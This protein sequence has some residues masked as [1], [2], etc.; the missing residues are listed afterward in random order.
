MGPGVVAVNLEGVAVRLDG[1]FHI[2]VVIQ[3]VAQVEVG[4]GKLAVDLEG[5][6]QRLDGAFHVFFAKQGDATTAVGLSGVG[7]EA[8]GHREL[9]ESPV[10]IP[11]LVTQEGT[12]VDPE[13]SVVGNDF[14]SIFVGTDGSLRVAL[15]GKGDAEVK[16]SLDQGGVD[17]ER[18]LYFADGPFQVFLLTQGGAQVVV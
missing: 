4:L 18:G 9:G 12:E 16:V 13:L 2:F 5:T 1:G 3:G 17:L 7:L 6:A 8:E 14:D 15:S 11:Y 10:V